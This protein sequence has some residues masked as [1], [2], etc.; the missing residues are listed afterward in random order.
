VNTVRFGFNH[1]FVNNNE[2]VQALNPA[3]GDVSLG[4]FTGRDAAVVSVT[5]LSTMSG[6]VGG[7]PSTKYDW[8]SF[9]VYDD[10]FWIKGKH[11]IKFG[12]AIER[13]LFQIQA[14][15]DPNGG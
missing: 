14:H 3:A 10:A 13:I 4:S 7:Y 11:S 12:V 6:G 2:S 5:G 8:N 1:E 9:Q 15:S